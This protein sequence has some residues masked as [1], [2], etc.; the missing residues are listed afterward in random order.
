MAA[1]L[2]PASLVALLGFWNRGAT[3]PTE[4]TGDSSSKIAAILLGSGL[5]FG[6]MCL[7]C[8]PVRLLYTVTKH[9]AAS[10][11]STSNAVWSA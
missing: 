6:I 3:E 7:L 10:S 5:M 9:D 2:L 1:I 11:I 8:K 4:K